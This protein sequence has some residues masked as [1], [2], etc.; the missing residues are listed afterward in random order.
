MDNIHLLEVFVWFLAEVIE[1]LC[2]GFEEH[3]GHNLGALATFVKS[4]KRA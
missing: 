3:N 2:L 4:F 1:I